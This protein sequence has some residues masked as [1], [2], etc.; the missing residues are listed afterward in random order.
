MC[1]AHPVTKLKT[2]SSLTVVE[3]DKNENAT[4]ILG[5]FSEVII[6]TLKLNHSFHVMHRFL[7]TQ[8]TTLSLLF[9][10]SLLFSYIYMAPI[11]KNKALSVN[12]R[13]WKNRV[14]S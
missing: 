10:L 6:N 13:I 1:S 2:L 8:C 14:K 3:P 7:F 5:S 4:Q 12:K 9:Y 11:L